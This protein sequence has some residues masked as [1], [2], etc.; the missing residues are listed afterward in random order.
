M[1]RGAGL[2]RRFAQETKEKVLV[3]MGWLHRQCT[4]RFKKG[5]VHLDVGFIPVLLER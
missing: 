1:G 5:G 3:D 2:L 4:G